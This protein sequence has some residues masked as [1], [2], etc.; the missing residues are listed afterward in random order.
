MS[1]RRRNQPTDVAGRP[2][3]ADA[4][5]STDLRIEAL[6]ARQR[7][8]VSRAQLQ[9]AG[10]A[11]HL[12]DYRIRRGKLRVLH[13][14][15]F[16]LGPLRDPLER[17]AAALL[18]CGAGAVLSHGT[19]AGVRELELEGLAAV[20]STPGGSGPPGAIH[21]SVCGR[22]PAPG[23]DIRVHRVRHL[24]A[25]EVTK[26]LGLAVTTPARTL[27]DLAA[28]EPPARLEQC[29]ARWERAGQ[30]TVA[31]VRALLRRYPARRGTPRLRSL[32]DLDGGP[33][34]TRSEAEA[35]FL[36][37]VRRAELPAPRTNVRVRGF[38][39]DAS[40]LSEKVVVEIDGRAYHGSASAFER[41]R[42]RDATLT[43][44][45]YRVLRI[46]WRQLVRAPEVVLVRLAQVL[47][48]GPVVNELEPR[49]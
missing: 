48:T 6:A 30:V 33:A 18:A 12:V 15:V 11:A 16:Q 44:A 39:V 20:P 5:P 31:E 29:L 7:G 14:G 24:P 13:R 8:L 38:E 34:L 42:R 1:E 4:A 25:D 27:L 41:D 10:M 32:I 9:S 40:W 49:P 3:A 43:A 23:E 28:D 21:V 46:T 35:R 47:G 22:H 45:G 17:E 36:A 26:C 2:G 19:A 37:L